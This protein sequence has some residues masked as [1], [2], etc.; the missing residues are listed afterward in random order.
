MKTPSCLGKFILKVPSV[1]LKCKHQAKVVSG[2]NLHADKRR[3][4]YLQWQR[5]G[6]GR[7]AVCV[8]LRVTQGCNERRREE[9]ECQAGYTFTASHHICQPLSPSLFHFHI[10]F[11]PEKKKKKNLHV[12]S[13]P[14][15]SLHQRKK[16][17][18]SIKLC[19][20]SKALNL[21]HLKKRRVI[22][23]IELE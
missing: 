21:L 11:V 23:A 20:V 22:T 17:N 1:N 15:C 4:L 10:P 5:A 18:N 7:K 8:S 9:W 16:M 14:R 3:L 12:T 6:C 2:W 19:I 13:V